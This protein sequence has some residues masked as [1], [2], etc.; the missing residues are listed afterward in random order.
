MFY[1]MDDVLCDLK[2]FFGID[3]VEEEL[4]SVEFFR[5]VTRLPA[6]KGAVRSKLEAYARDHEDEIKAATEV[7]QQ[8]ITLTPDQLRASPR[9]GPAPAAGQIAPLFDAQVIS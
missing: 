8:P 5:M 6:Y 2:V 9:L 3:D 4:T 7:T 1:Y